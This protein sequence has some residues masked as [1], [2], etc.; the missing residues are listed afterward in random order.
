MKI[1][2]ERREK[3]GKEVGEKSWRKEQTRESGR[4]KEWEHR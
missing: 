1:K 2:V 3:E 4:R